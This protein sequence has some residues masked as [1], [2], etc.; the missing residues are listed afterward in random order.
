MQ[1]AAAATAP[2]PTSPQ[3]PDG[4]PSKRRKTSTQQASPATDADIY[5]AAAKAEDAK[6]V[7]AIERIAAEAGE[8]KW[9]L[10]IADRSGV[11]SDTKPRFLTTGY[12]D[13]D[14][15]TPDTSAR[16]DQRGRRSF[17]RFNRDLE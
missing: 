11:D 10:S 17:G 4:P 1:R 14:Q 3:T 7:A 5:E 15:E 16:H 2:S 12:S 13:I 8:T 6:R 9:V